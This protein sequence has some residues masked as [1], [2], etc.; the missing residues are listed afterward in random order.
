MSGWVG[1]YYHYGVVA[2]VVVVGA[3]AGV[4]DVMVVV[5][6]QQQVY[7]SLIVR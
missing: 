6:E 2:A 7:G 1:H 3:V 5:C 4:G